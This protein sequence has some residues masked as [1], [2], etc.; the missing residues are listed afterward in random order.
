M[1]LLLE[2]GRTNLGDFR[3]GL[4]S[5]GLLVSDL[6]LFTEY[7]ELDIFYKQVQNSNTRSI[8]LV[9]GTDFRF[10]VESL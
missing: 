5:K 6:S 3:N 4:E 1:T 9:T 10:S 7:V 2:I 8:L